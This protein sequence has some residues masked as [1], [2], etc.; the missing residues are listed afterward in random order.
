MEQKELKAKVINAIV[1]SDS[2]AGT[3]NV[4]M[5]YISDIVRK[6]RKLNP[7]FLRKDGTADMPLIEASLEKSWNKGT[8]RPDWRK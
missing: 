7:S 8:F 5:E 3:I 1:A 2:D 6:S 4:T